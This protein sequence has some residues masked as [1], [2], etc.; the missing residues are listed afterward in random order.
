MKNIKNNNLTLKALKA[1]LDAM[2]ANNNK[3][4]DHTPQK[5]LRRSPAKV[6]NT[7]NLF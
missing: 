6:L 2:K 5:G 3:T 4:V 1:E 7:R